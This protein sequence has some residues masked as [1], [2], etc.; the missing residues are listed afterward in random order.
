MS[1]DGTVEVA[2]ITITRMMTDEPGEFGD[3]VSVDLGDGLS[4]VEALGMLRLAEDSILHMS[5][6][7][8]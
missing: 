3:L 5:D 2:R 8:G 1:D 6:G 7:D 4:T